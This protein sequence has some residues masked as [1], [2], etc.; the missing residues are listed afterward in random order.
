MF[1]IQNAQANEQECVEHVLCGEYAVYAG[2][3]MREDCTN[4]VC[5]SLRELH[6]E[7]KFWERVESPKMVLANS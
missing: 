1:R 3:M 2:S 4:D 7:R 5:D 6:E